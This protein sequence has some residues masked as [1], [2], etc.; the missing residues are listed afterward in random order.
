MTLLSEVF[1]R[2][3][4]LGYQEAARRRAEGAVPGRSRPVTVLMIAVLLGLAVTAAS[5]ALRQPSSAAVEARAL[6]ERR[7]AEQTTRGDQAQAS[8]DA[9]SVALAT[10]QQQALAGEDPTL[11]ARLGRDDGPSGVV[12]VRGPG[13][14]V[15]LT[16]APAPQ[17]ADRP[18][19]DHRVQDVDLQVV[20]NGLWA[21]GAEA[22]TVNGARLTSTTAIR[23]AGSAVLVNLTALS[24][25]YAIDAI[26]DPATLQT[27]LAQGLAG[28]HLATLRNTYG[29]GVKIVAERS[30]VLPGTGQVTLRYAS[31]PT[32]STPGAVPSSGVSGS[33]RPTEGTS[34]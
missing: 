7:I 13:L 4:D 33:P 12:A 31:T 20:V 25:P 32:S 17:G 22:I 11:L 2:P 15:T 29:I 14:R 6:L 18:D 34:P 5:L 24:S 9:V 1:R 21:A 28:Q 19:A 30:F 3:L 23:S 8:V 16:D 26:G 10:L 27:G